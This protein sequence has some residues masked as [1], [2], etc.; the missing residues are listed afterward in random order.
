MSD[1]IA[2][3]PIPSDL[4]GGSVGAAP[5][6][7]KPWRRAVAAEP[8]RIDF[9]ARWLLLGLCWL[10]AMVGLAVHGVALDHESAVAEA[11]AVGYLLVW[12]LICGAL[13]RQV[14]LLAWPC[15]TL[16][17]YCLSLAQ[18]LAASVVLLPLT[19]LAAS[20]PLPLRDAALAQ[21]DLAIG[22][23][24]AAAAAWVAER[25][26][27]GR[28]LLLAYISPVFQSLLIMLIGSI[29]QPGDRNGELIWLY[30][31]AGLIT[32]AISG[33]V[34]A[35]GL[36]GQVGTGYVELIEQIR[37]GEWR[38]MS[39]AKPEGIVTFP[40]FHAALAI[41][42]TW[43]A[44]HHRP[45]LAVIALLNVLMMLS[46]P[47]VGGH[48]LVDLFGGAVVA[49]ASIL[50]VRRLRAGIAV[51]GGATRARPALAVA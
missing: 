1:D 4:P 27:L 24:W 8:L 15:G 2:D 5:P 30:C 40:S 23:D 35:I 36:I 34:P 3:R 49:V 32:T 14:S 50:L 11:K 43:A 16:E 28:L 22:F 44:R 18:L 12:A 41:I 47:T 6:R 21:L 33:L 38:V 51:A 39:F 48:Y 25:P 31:V 46:T 45:T 42:L 10:V 17:D 9:A 20:T 7:T 13:A 19:Y 37:A 29:A 26:E